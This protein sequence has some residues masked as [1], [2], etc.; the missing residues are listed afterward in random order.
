[1]PVHKTSP[2]S[3]APTKAPLKAVKSPAKKVGGSPSARAEDGVPLS[4]IIRRRIQA[5]KA[6]FHAN[7]NIS[8]DKLTEYQI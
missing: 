2:K 6:R 1:M 5:K 3:K 4:T 7:D 8:E